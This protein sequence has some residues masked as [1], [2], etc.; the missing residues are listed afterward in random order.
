MLKP[1]RL[2]RRCLGLCKVA[3]NARCTYADAAVVMA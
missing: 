2:L 1:A 3:E